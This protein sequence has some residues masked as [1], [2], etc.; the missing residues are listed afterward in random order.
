MP[1]VAEEADPLLLIA[2]RDEQLAVAAVHQ[3]PHDGDEDQQRAGSDE[4]QHPLIDRVARGES[5][6]SQE[7]VQAVTAT[8]RL[9]ADQKN[10]EGR[11]QGLGEDREIGALHPALED[12]QA[13]DG[14]D[15][16]GTMRMARIVTSG[17]VNGFNTRAV[18]FC[19]RSA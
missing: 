2:D 7:V 19:P 15:E 12:A 18:R 14:C 3:L 4:E 16:A 13:E 6:E 11:G 8:G 1:V 5:E 9:L 17:E 10:R